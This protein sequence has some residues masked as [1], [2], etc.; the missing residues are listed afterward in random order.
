MARLARSL[1]VAPALA[2]VAADSGFEQAVVASWRQALQ[3]SMARWLLVR[4]AVESVSEALSNAGVRW[5]PIKGFDVCSRFY[6]PPESRPTTDLDILIE[7][8]RFDDARRCLG[9][10]GWSGLFE[11]ARAED[12]LRSEGYAWQATGPSPV[13]LE[14]HFRLWGLVEEGLAEVMISSAHPDPALGATGLRLRRD[15]AYL[16]AAVHAWLRETPRSLSDWRDLDRILRVSSEEEIGLIIV[17][18]RNGALGLPVCLSSAVAARLWP[19]SGHGR[20]LD[21]LA[22]ELLR[23]E[24]TVLE[25]LESVGFDGLSTARIVL[26]RLLS[27]R[28]SR[29]GLRS[30]WRRLWPHPGIVERETPAE[31]SWV[32]RRGAC[33]LRAAG[34]GS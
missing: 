4:E 29:A 6:D 23:R 22:P 14:V 33:L 26:A 34:F 1:G 18:A 31:W 3:L 16:L 10:A 15:H 7:P 21:A 17:G 5:A 11:G 20:I 25:D 19:Q 13:L 9:A 8:A 28:P 2:L 24:A 30:V 27:G 12:Y 32:R